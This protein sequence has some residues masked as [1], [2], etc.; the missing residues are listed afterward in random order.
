[1]QNSVMKYVVAVIAA[2]TKALAATA[3]MEEEVW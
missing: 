3:D 2:A 1:M